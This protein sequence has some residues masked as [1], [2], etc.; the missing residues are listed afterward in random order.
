MNAAGT[1]VDQIIYGDD[2]SNLRFYTNATER[3]RVTSGGSV[4]IGTVLPV[5]PFHVKGDTVRFENSAATYYVGISYDSSGSLISQLNS[6]GHLTLSGG[7]ASGTLRFNTAGS[8]AMRITSGGSVGIGTVSPSAPLHVKSSTGNSKVIFEHTSPSTGTGQTSMFVDGSSNAT[9]VYDNTGSYIIGTASNPVTGAGF[10]ERMRIDSSGNLLIGSSSLS[11]DN[12]SKTV[13]RQVGDN[14]TIKPY[15]CHS[16]N[17]TDS[18][19]SILEFYK[20][21]SLVGSI[22]TASGGLTFGSGSSGTER[23]RITS[24]GQL[25]LF[26][27]TSGAGNATLKYTTGTG[28]VTYDTSS[29]LVKENIVDCPYGL[30]EIVQLQPRKYFRI[31]DQANEVGLIAD[32]VQSIMPEFVPTGEKSLITGV[33][34]DTEIIAL[35]V[36]YDKMVAPLV[37]AI[38]DL[39]AK[40]ET[41]EE[42]VAALEN[43]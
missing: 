43:A 21:S 9:V 39:N 33:E 10:A 35:G 14:W 27:Q 16:F 34:E 38:K 12:V 19:G 29:R 2:S 11:F 41:L 26:S 25:F 3:M 8:E 24:G 23:M 36:N 40:I 31:D 17:R 18:D 13:I 32:E 28:A 20:S 1:A 5:A 6:T 30:A 7:S 15:I 42:K 4:G 22:G 37:Q